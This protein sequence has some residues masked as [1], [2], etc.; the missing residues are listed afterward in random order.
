MASVTPDAKVSVVSPAR[1]RRIGSRLATLVS[2][3]LLGGI[4]CVVS[5]GLA[6][7]GTVDVP[8]GS[9]VMGS[10]LDERAAALERS[11]AG[12]GRVFEGASLWI[13]Q[14]HAQK[15]VEVPRFRMMER[16]VTQIEYLAFVRTRGAP[17]PYVDA[18]TWSR[19]GTGIEY[20]DVQHFLWKKGEPEAERWRHPVVL[21]SQIEARSYCA[22][23]GRGRGGVGEL[24]DEAQWEKAARGEK[25][26]DYPWGDHFDPG[27]LNSAES[28][29]W[30][31]VAVGLYDGGESPYGF[32]DMA[33]NVFEWTASVEDDGL[34]I[35]KGGSW[36]TYG[37]FA[38]AAA[39]HARPLGLRHISIGFRCVLTLAK[40][41]PT[42]SS[43]SSRNSSSV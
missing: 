33:G 26:R 5:P 21:V 11:Y 27:L 38:R 42:A 20:Q 6:T 3:V 16:P 43:G 35:V 37:G 10:T 39:R 32:K 8:G 7:K 41:K 34:A 29:P 31:T 1:V 12:R 30:D 2:A 28:G 14:E 17:E 18:I 15:V 25:G 9:F 40:E 36:N 19:A 22:W 24:P 4:G 13:K 23:W